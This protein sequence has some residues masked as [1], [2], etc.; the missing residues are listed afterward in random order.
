MGGGRGAAGLHSDAE[1]GKKTAFALK[2][3]HFF[4]FSHGQSLPWHCVLRGLVTTDSARP[5]VDRPASL[6]TCS[7]CS[8][9]CVHFASESV[10][11]FVR[12]RRSVCAG[13]CMSLLNA[14][15]SVTK[16]DVP[17]PTV[18]S[19]RSVPPCASAIPRQIA[20]PSPVPPAA[21]VRDSSIR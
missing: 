2:P 6:R 16:T 9:T 3:Q 13:I 17:S 18:L 20:S 8:G 15:G 14:A 5:V 19:I 7:V 4:D 1:R 21:R 10:F 12:N 11:S